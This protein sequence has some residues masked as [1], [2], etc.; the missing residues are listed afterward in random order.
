M[1]EPG[2]CS[3]HA[4]DL[5]PE[6]VAIMSS[7]SLFELRCLFG[8]LIQSQLENKQTNLTKLRVPFP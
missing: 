4:P 3:L 5:G 1:T 6:L 7:S 8:I 2:A